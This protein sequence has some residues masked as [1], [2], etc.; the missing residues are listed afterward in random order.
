MYIDK[1]KHTLKGYMNKN[2]YIKIYSLQY[3]RIKCTSL[4]KK[5]H[6]QFSKVKRN[7]ERIDIIVDEKNRY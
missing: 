4:R 6:C 5:L 2:E 3:T 7:Q 1:L